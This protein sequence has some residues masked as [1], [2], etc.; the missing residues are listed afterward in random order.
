MTGAVAVIDEQN[1][2]AVDREANSRFVRLCILSMQ[3]DV[4]PAL[5]GMAKGGR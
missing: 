4:D 3:V 5:P 2:L 1:V